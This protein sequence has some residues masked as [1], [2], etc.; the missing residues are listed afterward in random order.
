MKLNKNTGLL[1][2]IGG[3]VFVLYNVILFVVAGFSGHGAAFWLSYTA[4]ILGSIVAAVS[5]V[6][7]S[8]SS[9]MMRD[10]FLGYPIL[11]HTVIYVVAEF[12]ISTLFIILDKHVPWVIPFI[13]QFAMLGVYVVLVL[14]C[15][16]TKNMINDVRQEVKTKTTFI[17]L[18]QADAAMLADLCE[19]PAAKKDFVEFAEAV[20]YSD[21]MSND[22]LAALESELQM[23]VTNAKMM[24]SD[25]D[26]EGA[27]KACKQAMLLL[28]ERNLKCKALK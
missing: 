6:A 16:F 12:I 10:W 20:K 21:P 19:D 26:T 2:G 3:T 1:M 17:N 14:S 8:K 25:G 9:P 27:L 22:M 11:R 7:F 23:R 18:L 13:L 28:K 15:L 4:M 5:V 24:L